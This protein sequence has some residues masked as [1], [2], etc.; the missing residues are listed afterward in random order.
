VN[1]AVRSGRALPPPIPGYQN[2]FSVFSE[3]VLRGTLAPDSEVLDLRAGATCEVQAAVA[4]AIAGDG[5]PLAE[6]L[7][8]C[9]LWFWSEMPWL[10]AVLDRVTRNRGE[11]AAAVRHYRSTSSSFYMS[12]FEA[13]QDFEVFRDMSSVLGDAA[14]AARWQEIIERQARVLADRRRAIGFAILQAI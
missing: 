13:L 6:K 5:G 8:T 9:D 10:L 2:R 11:I 7:R 14:E 4:A 1:L 3:S 12:P